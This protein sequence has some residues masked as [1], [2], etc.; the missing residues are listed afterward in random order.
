MKISFWYGLL[1]RSFPRH[2]RRARGQEM[3]GTLLDGAGPGQTRPSPAEALA[4]IGAGLRCRVRIR[5]GPATLLAALAAGFTGAVLTATLFAWA[6]WTATAPPLPSQAEADAVARSVVAAEP[7]RQHYYDFVFGDDGFDA[8][9][10]GYIEFEYDELTLRDTVR[11][12][13]PG[14]RIQLSHNTLTIT[15]ATPPAVPWLTVLGAVIGA[16]LGWVLAARVSRAVARR[17][18][19]ALATTMVLAL[20]TFVTLAP[21]CLYAC[22]AFYLGPDRGAPWIALYWE[23]TRLP[24]FIGLAAAALTVLLSLRPGRQTAALSPPLS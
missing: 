17:G 16:Y 15:R 7:V 19:V 13:L 10:P 1:L 6:A 8:G 9:S 18:A 23:P 12:E 22:L 11:P 2:Y 5:R 21:M 20:L 4:I 24:T 14:M 3:L